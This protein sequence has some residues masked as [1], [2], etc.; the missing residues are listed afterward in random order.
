MTCFSPTPRLTLWFSRSVSQTVG[1]VVNSLRVKP[2]SESVARITCAETDA[3]ASTGNLQLEVDVGLADSG[4]ESSSASYAFKSINEDK[5][6]VR[7]PVVSGIKAGSTNVTLTGGVAG[8]ANTPFAGYRFGLVTVNVDANVTNSELAIEEVRLDGVTEEMVEGVLGLGF[9][10]DRDSE[11]IGRIR[12]PSGLPYSQVSVVWRGW[13]LA[14]AAGTLPALTMRYRILPR[15]SPVQTPRA[16]PVSDV[17]N[18][19]TTIA[20]AFD[21]L[22]YAE[23]SS[24]PIVA[25]PGSIIAFAL[26]RAADGGDG[27]DEEVV[28]INQYA[29]VSGVS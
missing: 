7:G 18:S 13:I 15:P 4:D 14:R 2:G 25:A 12:V 6:L 1:T 16:L 9:A 24:S 3:P 23:I 22:E 28:L 8:T 21:E 19:L 29:V 11:F 5:E 26:T 27:Y 20:A 10:P 17:S